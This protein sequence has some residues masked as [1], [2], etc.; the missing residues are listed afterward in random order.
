MLTKGMGIAAV[1]AL[2][3]AS[4]FAAEDIVLAER[5]KSEYQIVVPN[6]KNAAAEYA[7]KELQAFLKQSTG[8]TLPIVQEISASN[9]PSIHI[10]FGGRRTGA[11]FAA[12]VKRLG[13]DGV[14][15][16]TVGDDLI[17]LG[18]NDRG[19]LYSVYVFLERYLGVRFLARDC[20]IVPKKRTL[21]IPEIDYAYTPPFAYREILAY[22]YAYFDFAARQ[23]LNGGNMVQVLGRPKGAADPVA[24]GVQIVPFVHSAAGMVPPSK[25]FAGHP[26]YFGLVNG[27]RRSDTISGQLCYT[28]PDVL[29]ICTE[30]ALKYLGMSKSIAYVDIS[31]NDAWV[32][33]WGAC[34]CEKCAA[35]VK[36]EGAQS[37]TILRFVNAIA[38]VVAKEY[39]DRFVETLAYQYSITAPAITKPRDNVVVRLCHHA[40]Y[41]HGIEGEELGGEFRKGIDDWTK[42]CKKVF[43]WHYGV[44]FWSYLAPNPNLVSLA[45]DVKY[46]NRKGVNGL[47]LQAN[48]QSAGGELA[49]MRQYLFTQLVWDPSQD[50]MKLRREFCK[51]YYG[52]AADKALEFLAMMDEWARTMKFHIPMN[53]WRPEEVTPP[54]VVAS[55][56][57]T[58]NQAYDKAGKDEYRNRVEKLLLPFWYMQLSWP[59]RYGLAKKDGA[60]VVARAKAVME[61]NDITTIS[62]GPANA[63]GYIKDREAFFATP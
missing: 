29:K 42:L 32:G 10:G 39:P 52:P 62:E 33:N 59:D 36:E 16:N 37:G 18:Q 8:A 9:G 43:V 40:C 19:T 55:A 56:L 50:P 1:A 23:R 53:G 6:Q 22:D 11:G 24:E 12:K 63:A 2:T 14:L 54:E 48:I 60:K 20:T 7:A 13:T 17:L 4:A 38:D 27:Q 15:I 58:L 30:E 34:E 26:E 45:K 28:N 44:N 51:G 49:E 31:Q 46:Y 21:K 41:F 25:Y 47:M 5:G 61:R 3:V 35:V 57:A